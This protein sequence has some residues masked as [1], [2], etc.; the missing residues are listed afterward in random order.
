ML[1]I[2]VFYLVLCSST[3]FGQSLTQQNIIQGNI[4][5]DPSVFPYGEFLIDRIIYR[6]NA[7]SSAQKTQLGDQVELEMGIRYQKD[8]NSFVRFRFATDPTENRKDNE[9][10]R[11]EI[12]YHKTFRK[13]SFQFDLGLDTNDPD[14]GGNNL[15]LDIDSDDTFLSY[16]ISERSS[17]TFYPFNF[18]S[19]VGDE[20]NTRDVTRIS[21]IEGS[22][23]S[24]LSTAITML[25]K[26]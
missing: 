9:T 3:V 23:T 5:A 20:F 21:Y 8:E 22:P 4:V 12:I 26:F 14:S 19:D 2:I 25:R 17:F 11:F 1:K 7:Y 13:L 6:D 18:R 16:Q 10:S 15:G 24:V